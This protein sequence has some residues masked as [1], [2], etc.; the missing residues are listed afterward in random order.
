MMGIVLIGLYSS[1]I[2]AIVVVINNQFSKKK[3]ALDKKYFLK[4]SVLLFFSIMAVYL[5]EFL[6]GKL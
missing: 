3:V 4:A 5:Y 1:F 2:A 6:M